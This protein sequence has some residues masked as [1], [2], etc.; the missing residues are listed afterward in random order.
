MATPQP[1]PASAL[2]KRCDASKF[3]F[4]TTAELEELQESLG[5]KRALDAIHFGLGVRREGYNIF[6]VGPPGVG[7]HSATLKLLQ[8]RAASEPSPSDWCYVQNFAEP[9]RPRALALPAGR[10]SALRDDVKRFIEGLRIQLPAAFDSEEY[11]SRLQGLHKKLEEQRE[12]TFEEFRK[13]AEQRDV[14]LLRTPAGLTLGIL[15]NGKLLE[16]PEFERLP[17]EEQI[18]LKSELD[19]FGDELLKLVESI[20]ASVHEHREEVKALNRSVGQEV[21]SRGARVL[22]E[23]YAD[24]PTILDHISALQL[25]VV[26]NAQ[27]FLEA[28]KEGSRDLRQLLAVSPDLVR[29]EINVL[30]DNS[31]TRGAPVVFEERPSL[32]QLLGRVEHRS[33][34]GALITDFSLIKKGA[35]HRANGGYLVLDARKVLTQPFAWEELKRALRSKEIHIESFGEMLGLLS[36]VSLQPEPIP[37]AIKVVLIG[38]RLLYYLLACLD[39]EFFDEFKVAADFEEE[40]DRTSETDLLYARLIASLAKAEQLKPLDAEAVARVVEF[41]AR[42]ASDAK[43]VSTRTREVANLLRESDYWAQEANREVVT[44]AD[45]QRSL[46]EKVQRSG[47]LRD[48]IQEQIR[49]GVLLVS[50]Q[51][52][53]VGQVQ[54]LSVVQPGD[55]AFAYP[56]RI[57]ARVR[58]GKGEV[59]DIEREAELGG[60]LHSKGVL[61]L[62]GFLGARYCAERPLSLSASLV[63]EQ[64]YGPV[65]GDSA[66]AAELF[67][68]LSSLADVPIKQNLAV[69]G[70]VNQHGQIQPI[71][72]VNEKIEGFFDT[73]KSAGVTGGGVLIPSANVQHLMLRDDVVEA[74]ASSLFNV[75]PISTV[76]EGIEVLTGVPAGERDAAGGFAP[77]SINQR[78]EARFSTLAERARSFAQPPRAPGAI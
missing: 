29:Y 44:A 31:L 75:Y 42:I 37:L 65:E 61:I 1:L 60:P 78:V 59:I 16:P 70:S 23:H 68:L 46:D 17:S 27:D 19:R 64:S 10:A 53:M 30:V 9:H 26:E 35:L 5:Q 33:H 13:R 2:C 43:K 32:H 45:V 55:F 50:P 51:G 28:G 58:L 76:D 52:T 66:S 57:T 47:R 56:V 72:A 71:G 48:R 63:F 40:I 15:R 62:A 74:A 4:R 11:R 12:A 69:T 3:L 73:C 36:T 22:R 14:A 67:A 18:R 34:L 54:G 77:G 38:D 20:H 24:L 6:V 7:K 49:R 25:D 41:G 8:Q 21:V 39:P